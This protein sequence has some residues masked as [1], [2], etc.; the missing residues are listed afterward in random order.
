MP[1]VL[2]TQEVELG[3][4]QFEASLGKN[5]A[6]LHLISKLAMV[7]HTHSG[8]VRVGSWSKTNIRQKVQDP[9]EKNN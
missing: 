7:V 6:R 5:L 4:W 2:A 9:F 3:G 1:V 8:D